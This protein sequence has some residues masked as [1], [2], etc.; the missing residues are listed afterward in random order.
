MSGD[1]LQ[2]AREPIRSLKREGAVKIVAL[3]VKT[4]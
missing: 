2:T 3:P 1:A 4:A